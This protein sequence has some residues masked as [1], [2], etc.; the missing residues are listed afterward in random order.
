M[1]TQQ[2]VAEK[3]LWPLWRC[4]FDDYKKRYSR[5][6][7]DHFENAVRSA[8]YT[9]K[10]RAYLTSFQARIPSEIQAQYAQDIISV[11]DSG[12]DEEILNWLRE[13]TTYLCLLV[14]LMNQE[15]KEAMELHGSASDFSPAGI[16]SD[17]IRLLP[18][19]EE[20][21]MEIS[22]SKNHVAFTIGSTYFISNLING[23]YPEYQRVIPQSFDAHAEL[24]LHDFAVRQRKFGIRPF[25]RTTANPSTRHQRDF[26]ELG[27]GCLNYRSS[28]T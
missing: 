26:L 7:W 24:N 14:R 6:I 16:L 8:A 20:E 17:V 11:I 4:I 12:C 18:D 10:L 1:I 22:W 27:F 13:E 25:N 23:E 5:E 3:L 21:K 9:G 2:Q 28:R 15:R 19:G